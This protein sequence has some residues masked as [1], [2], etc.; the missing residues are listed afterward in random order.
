MDCKW[1]ADLTS[2]TLGKVNVIRLFGLPSLRHYP[3]AFGSF[4]Q[5][6]AAI[7]LDLFM[8]RGSL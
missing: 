6:S 8:N 2:R 5:K 1:N 3:I 4:A 7:D